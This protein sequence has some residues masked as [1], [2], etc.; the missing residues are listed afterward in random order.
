[1]GLKILIPFISLLNI[2][3]TEEI[4]VKT[5]SGNVRGSS[6]TFTGQDGQGDYYSFKGIPYAE[7]PV[8]DLMWRDPVPINNWGENE[9][10]GTIK[11]SPMCMQQGIFLGD[12]TKVVGSLDCLYLSI[13]T[14]ELPSASPNM[15]LKPVFFWI[16]GGGF[17]VGSGEM[18]S[19]PDYLLE[20]GMVVVTINYRLGPFGFMA[21]DGSYASG[22]QG[23]KDQ[24]VALRWVKK[25]IANFGGDPN[26]I[27][28]AG[29][30]AGAVSVHAHVLSPLGK[31]E[32][33]FHSAIS[34]SGTMLMAVKAISDEEAAEKAFMEFYVNNCL[35][36]AKLYDPENLQC[37]K[38]P[39]AL[40]M[41]AMRLATPSS[42]DQVKT[43][44]ESGDTSTGAY[45]TRFWPSIDYNSASPFF[46]SHPVTIL[47][48]KQQ[49]MVPFMTGLNSD[50]GA[51]LT[52]A[53]WKYMKEDDN[54]FAR[55]WDEVAGPWMFM[56]DY[57]QTYDDK[58]FAR[59][60][61]KFYFGNK[62]QIT[63]ENFQ[64]FND[65]FTDAFFSAPNTET[66]KLHAMSPA[67]VYNYLLT[68]RGSLTF[69]V[70]FSGGDEEA[71]K[72]NMGVTHADDLLY[73]WKADSFLNTTTINTEEDKKF[74]KLWQKLIT[75]FVKYADPTPVSTD[76]IPKWKP[77]QDSRA[78]CVYMDLNLEPKE[79]H[80]IFA[81]RMEFWNRMIYQDVLEKY[82]VSEE[83]DNLLV[84]IDSALVDAEKD[85]N[86]DDND[87][88]KQHH[89]HGKHGK[90]KQK[91]G[92]WRRNLKQ[93][94]LKKRKR[95]A[96]RLKSIK[97]A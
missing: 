67:P 35:K 28:I 84:E 44:V 69:N 58:L 27:T 10:D 4:T 82:A 30:S 31:D 39:E 72:I 60:F 85:D 8:G 71:N 6:K 14:T 11:M 63:K 13:S 34:F 22:N 45:R 20:S 52:A 77:A 46:G 57:N 73:T 53:N 83:E 68:Y 80:R 70:F 9:V 64:A 62:D 59:V 12:P 88:D 94:M 47:F 37:N 65:L 92:N 61:T 26:R 78:A 81:E 2:I 48:N 42:P 97:C 40:V 24:L 50:E 76:E 15:E 93:K 79:K 54:Q 95:L 96:R 25:N 89:K 66:V 41:E 36:D 29:E 23:L 19:G 55:N 17:S 18:G 56:T 87:D 90:K 5:A 16:H 49:K 1:M 21:L 33:L 51:M 75:N 43:N 3:S 7:P 38:N 74:L 32:N 91:K 86:D